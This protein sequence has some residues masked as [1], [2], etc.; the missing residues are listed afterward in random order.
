MKRRTIEAA[1]CLLL[2][3][4]VAFVYARVTHYS[5]INFD[6]LAYVYGN[7]HVT[8]GLT[9]SGI[10]WA[11][12]T[13]DYIYWQPIT[14]LSHMLDVQFYGL[15][16][17]GHHATNVGLHIF[18]TTLLYFV[19]RSFKLAI[20][21]SALGAAVFA[22]HPL[23]VESVAWVAER[24]DVLSASFCLLTILAYI[25]Y[26]KA[27]SR[28]KY[29]A[30]CGLMLLGL[31][32]KPSLVVI[33]LMLLLLDFWPLGR[34]GLG[35]RLLVEKVP[36]FGMAAL[37]SA[38]TLWGQWKGGAIAQVPLLT[39]IENAF[40]AYSMYIRK[41]IWPDRLAIFYPYRTD[42][43]GWRVLG[44]L[45]VLAGIT[46][47]VFDQRKKRPYL[48][49]GW[50]W[51]LIVPLPMMGFVQ[52]GQ[53]AFADRFTHLAA[54][55]G[56]VIVACGCAEISSRIH[57]AMLTAA[58][59]LIVSALAWSSRTQLQFWQNNFTLY[60]HALAVTNNNYLAHYNLG[61]ALEE[62]GKSNAAMEHYAESVRINPDLAEGH[63]SLGTLLFARGDVSGSEAQFAQALDRKP[64]FADAHYAL[65]LVLLRE[66]KPDQAA[67]H[68][69][70]ALRLNIGPQYAAECRRIL[71]EPQTVAAKGTK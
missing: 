1:I 50:L 25:A 61:Q 11:F 44:G 49:F 26:A 41:T 27:P 30:V 16:A 2:A 65:A 13:T 51:F 36:L 4:T 58:G 59:L 35:S 37:S 43:V 71:A 47:L 14:W 20:W 5:F 69:S 8:S 52:A 33:P 10:K 19:L 64:E 9:W 62:G 28:S 23:R 46:W 53:Q 21:P 63:Y 32:C 15:N 55:G 17:G 57:P 6:D 40:T 7:P 42:I 60:E 39:R 67:P 24:K 48:A 3:V 56:A 31:M 54:I 29:F 66:N 34:G 70:D 45:I 22:L 38:V 12:L 18:N 68:L